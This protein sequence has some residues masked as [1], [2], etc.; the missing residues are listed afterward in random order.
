MINQPPALEFIGA[1]LGEINFTMIFN[2]SL[3][4]DP[5]EEAQR[6]RDLCAYGV[7]DYLIIGNEVIGDYMWIIDSVGE[8]VQAFDGN[9]QIIVSSINVKLK[10]YVEVLPQ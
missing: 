4:V 7:A 6:V 9:G 2:E 5:A 8:E 1:G 10:E 3:G